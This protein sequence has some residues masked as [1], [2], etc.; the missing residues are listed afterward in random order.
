[1]FAGLLPFLLADL[2]IVALVIAFP[3]VVMFLPALM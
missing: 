3:A 1:L 2:A